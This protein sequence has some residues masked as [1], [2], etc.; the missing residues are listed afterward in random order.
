M[1]YLEENFISVVVVV[2][3]DKII[4]QDKI[5]R[6]GKVLKARF[7]YYEVIIIDNMSTDG[8]NQL[9]KRLKDK[10][11]IVE[12]PKKHN[13]QQAMSAGIDIAIGDYLV[14]IEDLSIDIN[15]EVII[16][17]YNECLKG[18]DFVFYTPEKTSWTSKIFYLLLNCYFKSSFTADISSSVITL[19]SRRGQNRT[20]A[21]GSRIVNRYV[22]YV[23]CGLHCSS[24]KGNLIYKNKRGWI[25]N[26]NLMIDTFIYYTDLITKFS[27]GVA[28]GFF[29]ISILTG[30][31][32][33]VAFSTKPTEPGWAS[34]VFLGS[35]AFSGIFL[36][37]AIVSKY[38]YHI[39]N[40]LS[41]AKNYVFR[42]VDKN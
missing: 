27:I 5:E 24:L 26:L 33:V 30:I 40:N 25:Q 15:Y 35:M 41:G 22:S 20:A 29:I 17:M 9:L 31:Y 8:T 2:S 28:L 19:S 16:D 13:S 1:S 34:V 23:L 39:L 12:L 10:L 14:E 21:I 4:I 38:L 7:K 6:I 11:T 42:S 3:N 37:F 36:M 18:N 32:S